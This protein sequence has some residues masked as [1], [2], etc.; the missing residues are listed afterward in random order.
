MTCEA[1]QTRNKNKIIPIE[2]GRRK[3]S[4]INTEKDLVCVT[5]VDNGVFH[6]MLCADYVVTKIVKNVIR[7]EVIVELKGCD[8]KHGCEQILNTARLLRNCPED[9]SHSKL[10]AIV[11][12][13]RV[14][15]GGI[16]LRRLQERFAK[17][18][19]GSLRT[20]SGNPS[21][22]LHELLA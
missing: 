22:A 8:V 15:R 17:E 4:I 7:G 9:R 10:N 21:L 6:N 1:H 18:F 5:K 20:R 11:V 12:S 14:P 13:Q 3:L 19:T 2:E 16:D